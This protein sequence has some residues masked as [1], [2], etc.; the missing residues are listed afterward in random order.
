MKGA[1]LQARRHATGKH[2]ICHREQLH[3]IPTQQHSSR[4]RLL[5]DGRGQLQ[6]RSHGA[7]IQRA[8]GALYAM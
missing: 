5:R 6:Q 1:K 4:L 2:R 8:A 3:C 7:M